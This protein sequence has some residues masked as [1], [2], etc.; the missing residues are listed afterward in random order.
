[1]TAIVTSSPSPSSISRKII[2]YGRVSTDKQNTDRQIRDI[3]EYCDKNGFVL[4]KMVTETISSGKEQRKID[5]VIELLQPGDILVVTELSRIGRSLSDVF[6]KLEII[7]KKKAS[8]HFIDTKIVLKPEEECLGD[9][10]NR[11]VIHLLS[12]FAQLERS[13]LKQ[14]TLSGLATARAKNKVFGRPK[15]SFKFNKPEKQKEIDHWLDQ[16]FSLT[17]VAKL[18]NI[19]R[20]TLYRY[21]KYKKENSAEVPE[22][23]LTQKEKEL[24]MLDNLDQLSLKEIK[25][26]KKEKKL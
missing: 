26:L 14:R 1:M 6:K 3:K 13:F 4:D 15:N 17:A 19:S 21:L 7:Q 11:T 24:K 8:V 5:S 23:V 20:T 10:V 22:L 9:I 16:K 2:G 12:V 25:K 18:S